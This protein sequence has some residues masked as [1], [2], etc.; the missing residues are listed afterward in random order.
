MPWTA[1]A[2]RACR[3]TAQRDRRAAVKRTA[4]HEQAAMPQPTVEQVGAHRA[5]IRLAPVPA[6]FLRAERHALLEMA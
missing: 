2:T 5:D 3:G 4:S 6:E 1:E